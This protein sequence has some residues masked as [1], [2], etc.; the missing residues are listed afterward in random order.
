MKLLKNLTITSILFTTAIYAGGFDNSYHPDAIYFGD[1]RVEGSVGWTE[2]NVVGDLVSGGVAK[3]TNDIYVQKVSP[4]GGARYMITP[5]IGC[6]IQT[7]KPYR[8]NT[9]YD[10]GIYP[11]MPTYSSLETQLDSI[12]CGY[13]VAASDL[14]SVQFI[15]G[16]NRMNGYGGFGTDIDANG[17]TTEVR[18]LKFKEGYFGMFGLGYEIPDYA[19]R[20]SAMYYPEFKTTASGQA[21]LQV[22]GVDAQ[23]VDAQVST[24][25]VSPQRLQVYL[26]SGVHPKWL[27]FLGY[28]YAQW[29]SVP[30]LNVVFSS[31]ITLGS[32]Q[33]PGASTTLFQDDAHYFYFG[34]GHMLT[35][36]IKLTSGLFYEPQRDNPVSGIRTPSRGGVVSGMF[37]ASY[38]VNSRLSLGSRCS[39]IRADP[40]NVVYTT[41]L[42]TSVTGDFPASH[43]RKLMIYGEYKL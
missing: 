17:T 7:Q 2:V 15:A 36:T 42:S 19:L 30:S 8:A 1:S 23:V 9:R 14:A 4:V 37:G 38:D 21:A 16:V 35:K 11:G 18:N 33:L 43:G 3:T 39:F 26:Q 10:Q 34:F 31:P 12:G 25:V 6:S 20:V 28:I 24:M 40:A 29:K 41:F 22:N 32:S 13:T 27:V 5:K